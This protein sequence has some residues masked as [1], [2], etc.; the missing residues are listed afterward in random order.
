MEQIHK[1]FKLCGSP[2]EEYWSKSKLPHATSFK[3]Q[4]SYRRRLPDTFKDFPDSA[5]ELVDTLL[6]FEPEKRGTA[7]S[8]LNSE[9]FFKTDD[10]FLS[11]HPLKASFDFR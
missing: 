3:P 11:H 5:F 9:V 8:A 2:S 6:S 7:T 1:I 4:Q 10:F